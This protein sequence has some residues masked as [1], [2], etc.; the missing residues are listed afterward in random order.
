M[1]AAGNADAWAVGQMLHGRFHVRRVVW[2]RLAARHERRLDEVIRK[3]RVL[4]AE[5][6][7]RGKK[8]QAAA[9]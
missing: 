6:K 3:A 4:V 1:K 9:R 5:G 8:N 7:S 2:G